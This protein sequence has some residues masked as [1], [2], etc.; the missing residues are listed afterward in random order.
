MHL[1][2]KVITAFLLIFILLGIG[3]FAY[4]NLE[5]WS[6]VDALYF[7]SMTITTVGYGDLVPSTDA[8]KLFTI[9]FSFAGISIALVILFSIGGAYYQK[10]RRLI[11][12][13]IQAYM[14]N[15]RK[16]RRKRRRHAKK[17][18]HKAKRETLFSFLRRD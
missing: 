3:T 4:H 8:S 2:E 9:G 13:R 1:D 17:R 16:M 7:T 6:Y 14:E 11:R 5:G 15:R 10:E 12:Y 18:L